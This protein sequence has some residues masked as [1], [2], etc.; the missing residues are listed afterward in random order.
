MPDEPDAVMTR[1]ASPC[2][3]GTAGQRLAD[4]IRSHWRRRRGWR[5]FGGNGH[6]D[7]EHS[8]RVPQGMECVFDSAFLNRGAIQ[9]VSEVAR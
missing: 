8:L 1:L 5:L 7:L 6:S 9:S 4:E 2:G 3:N